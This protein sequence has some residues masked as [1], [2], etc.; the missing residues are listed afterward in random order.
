MFHFHPVVRIIIPSL[1]KKSFFILKEIIIMI[2]KLTT[3][4][5]YQN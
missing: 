3:L 5:F 1:K 4:I 2:S